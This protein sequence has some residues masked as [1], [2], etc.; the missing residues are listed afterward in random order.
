MCE[1]FQ[2][3]IAEKRKPAHAAGHQE[4]STSSPRLLRL[5][6]SWTE[7]TLAGEDARG[8]RALKSP[9]DT[10]KETGRE[11]GRE[12]TVPEKAKDNG[13]ESQI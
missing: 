11:D 1:N 8:P 4:L 2:T 13:K 9:N 10:T 7:R 6:P 5:Q 12:E 3:I